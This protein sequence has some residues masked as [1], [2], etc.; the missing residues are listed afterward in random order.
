MI[1][2]VAATPYQVFTCINIRLHQH[3]NEQADIYLMRFAV[4]LAEIYHSLKQ[5][6]VFTNVYVLNTVGMKS[7]KWGVIK[8]FWF[9]ERNVRRTFRSKCYRLLYI[10]Q[11]GDRNNLFYNLLLRK[12]KEMKL[13]FYDEGLSVYVTGFYESSENMKMLFHLMRYR[14]VNDY[15][16]CLKV[17]KPD[18]L[19]VRFQCAISQIPHVQKNDALFLNMV[20]CAFNYKNSNDQYDDY[21]YIYLEQR[22][23]R[24][25]DTETYRKDYR[26]DHIELLNIVAEQIGNENIL[27]KK[28]PITQDDIYE[29]KGYS[30][31]KNYKI[32]WEVIL[33]NKD[34]HNKVL[35][36]VNSTA[37]LTPK[38]VFN[39]EP[40]VVILAKALKNEGKSDK[41]WT[42]EI[43]Q[44]VNSVYQSYEHTEKFIVPS[45]FAELRECI[46]RINMK[47][48]KTNMGSDYY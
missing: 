29:E 15:I 35:I 23:G 18:M 33:L 40:Y 34:M 13:Y 41:V 32:P 47:L 5:T 46:K 27:V 44:M 36:T 45:D 4:D 48:E 39:E 20:N 19:Q 12:N 31:A 21:R 16:D 26:F 43:Q 2:F 30:L 28:H 22:F 37:V 9:T 38:M 6:N 42:D 24:Y 10:T 8:D 17:Y 3:K 1:A 25:L 11:V 14:Y 7:S